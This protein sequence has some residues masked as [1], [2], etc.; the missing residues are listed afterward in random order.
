ML[1]NA[2]RYL[3]AHVC[4]QNVCILTD[5]LW[6][7]KRRSSTQTLCHNNTPLANLSHYH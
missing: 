6:T 1:I 5:V 2:A 3:C 7:A 4:V